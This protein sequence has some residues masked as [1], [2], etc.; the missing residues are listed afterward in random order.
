PPRKTGVRSS[1]IEAMS[2]EPTP[3]PLGELVPEHGVRRVPARHRQQRFPL[4][5]ALP[6][7]GLTCAAFA[8]AG[9]VAGLVWARLGIRGEPIEAFMYDGEPIF[10]DEV[11]AARLFA[12]DGTFAVGGAATGLM[13]GAALYMAF[14]RH[15]PWIVGALAV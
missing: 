5:P 12:M 14:R 3:D 15:G 8:V 6:A 11:A 1:R 9:V 4:G 13:L 10:T 2:G 7:I